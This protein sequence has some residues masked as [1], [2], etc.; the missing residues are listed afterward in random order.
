[1]ITDVDLF[2]PRATPVV[3]RDPVTKVPGP[4]E[5]VFVPAGPAAGAETKGRYR[6]LLLY[7]AIRDPQEVEALAGEHE[8]RGFVDNGFPRLSPFLQVQAK[9]LTGAIPGDCWVVRVKRFSWWRGLV[10]VLMSLVTPAA[11][12]SWLVLRPRRYRHAIMWPGRRL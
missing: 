6:L 3:H 9:T 7:E 8:V 11:Y 2:V 12:V 1:R 4:W 5:G 10:L